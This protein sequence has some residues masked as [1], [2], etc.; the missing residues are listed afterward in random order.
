MTFLEKYKNKKLPEKMTPELEKELFN[1]IQSK[2]V[3]FISK[4]KSD[5]LNKDELS[6]LKLYSKLGSLLVSHLLL[7]PNTLS[8][9]VTA[10]NQNIEFYNKQNKVKVSVDFFDM[11]V[12]VQ[13]AGSTKHIPLKNGF[14]VLKSGYPQ[15]DDY[16]LFKI[17]LLVLKDPEFYQDIIKSV[18]GN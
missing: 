5:S 14:I 7:D 2:S 9:F 3:I 1:E 12:S 17:Y 4:L 16:T 18:Y 6:D 15:F 11:T 8:K 13:N 10:V